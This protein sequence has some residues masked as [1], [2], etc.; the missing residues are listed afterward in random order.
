[1][2]KLVKSSREKLIFAFRAQHRLMMLLS[3]DVNL[4]SENIQ[5]GMWKI[6]TSRDILKENSMQG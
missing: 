4:K 3:L 6:L 2:S 5:A 1:M